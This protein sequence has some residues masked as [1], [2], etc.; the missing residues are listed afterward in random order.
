MPEGATERFEG[1]RDPP[2]AL[3]KVASTDR[4]PRRPTAP[5]SD[6]AR[7]R[8]TV[9]SRPPCSDVEPCHGPFWIPEVSSTAPTSPARH[10]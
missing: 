2:R 3:R 10:G 1:A 4:A 5:R 8:L 9:G 6:P 7:G